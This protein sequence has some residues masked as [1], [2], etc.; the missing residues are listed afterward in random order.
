[1]SSAE[2]QLREL[3]RGVVDLVREEELLERLREGRPLRVKS[4]GAVR[5][6]GERIRTSCDGAAPWACGDSYQDAPEVIF[7]MTSPG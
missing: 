7:L 6:D 4:Q 2:R 1:M 3:R 5:L